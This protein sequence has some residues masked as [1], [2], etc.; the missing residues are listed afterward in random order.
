MKK[1]TYRTPGNFKEVKCK[2]CS[3]KTVK[4]DGGSI[5]GTCFRCVIKS[6]SPNSV[7]LTDLS[8]EDYIEFIQNINKKWKTKKQPN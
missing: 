7:I 3:R 1:N 8:T 4:I 5:S 2:V 6:T